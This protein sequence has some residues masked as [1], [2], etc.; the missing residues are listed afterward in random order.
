MQIPDSCTAQPLLQRVAVEVRMTRRARD[1]P[2]VGHLRNV[3]GHEQREERVEGS[4]GMTDG[5]DHD[6]G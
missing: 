2:D 1:A 4:G 6:S 3:V 5:V